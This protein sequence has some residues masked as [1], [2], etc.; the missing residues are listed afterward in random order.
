ML[1]S[2]DTQCRAASVDVRTT[3][4]RRHLPEG[5]V[6]FFECAI[7]HWPP[8]NAGYFIIILNALKN[9]I[10]WYI[11]AIFSY[12]HFLQRIGSAWAVIE[13]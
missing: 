8:N 13:E 5:D 9:L 6:F 2:I 1:S 10:L 11:K 3:A 7:F 4:E 12:L